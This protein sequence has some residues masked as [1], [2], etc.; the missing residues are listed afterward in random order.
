VS[1]C[2][3]IYGWDN[4][5]AWDAGVAFDTVY[6]G[7]A[8]A[9]IT[10]NAGTTG[11][12]FGFNSVDATAHYADIDYGFYIFNQTYRVVESGNLLATPQPFDGLQRFTVM[13]I[14]NVVYYMVANSF[15]EP[16]EVYYDARIPNT[17][18]PGA[19][20]YVSTIPSFNSLILDSSLYS[21]SDGFCVNETGTT[22]AAPTELEDTD[23]AV[24]HVDL[25]LTGSGVVRPL[26]AGGPVGVDESAILGIEMPLAGSGTM[27]ANEGVYDGKMYVRLDASDI[28]LFRNSHLRG[29]MQFGGSGS[30]SPVDTNAVFG[31]QLSIHLP[32]AG[33]ASG[34]EFYPSGVY[35]GEL[36]LVAAGA[37]TGWTNELLTSALT[38]S[39]G[40]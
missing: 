20:F 8:Y 35:F 24:V 21:V 15:D 13:R 31:A 9:T 25:G 17:P 34:E 23:T 19:I 27:S 5:A 12:A 3:P 28:S 29:Y 18:L 11:A 37:Y 7:D 10:V 38:G 14:G 33:Y 4:T 26:G 22:W 16:H 40:L 6:A 36:P 30:S 39:F 1:N 32:L 2:S